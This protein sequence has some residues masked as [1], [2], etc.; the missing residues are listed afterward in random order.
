MWLTRG[1]Y[2]LIL[3][4]NDYFQESHSVVAPQRSKMKL[5]HKS[6]NDFD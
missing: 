3:C 6:E 5:T 1:K 4:M 2:T